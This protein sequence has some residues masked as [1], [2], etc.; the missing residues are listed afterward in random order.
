MGE[1]GDAG[2]GDGADGRSV[3]GAAFELDAVDA[4]VLDEGDGGGE[5]LGGGDFVGAHGE[6]ADLLAWRRGGLVK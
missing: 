6:V 2:G 3:G 5:G 4:A 1:Y